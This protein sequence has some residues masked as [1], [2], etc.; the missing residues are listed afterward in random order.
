MCKQGDIILVKSYK[1]H[2]SILSRHSFV[3]IDDEGGQ[4]QGVPFDFIA[5]VM[6]SFKN[7]E[8]K[9]RKLRYPGNFPITAS[10]EK[11]IDWANDKEGYIK[12]EQF[13]YFNKEKIQFDVIGELNEETYNL[14]ILFIESLAEKSIKID[15][16]VDN[17]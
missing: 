1:D 6:S 3:V 11:M 9:R 4:V 15:Q 2:E 12:A 14:L 7:D 17:L 10:D 5:L 8:Q 13:Y 16:I